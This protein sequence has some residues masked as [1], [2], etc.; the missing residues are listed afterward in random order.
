MAAPPPAAARYRCQAGAG[1]AVGAGGFTLIEI[2]V[3]LA[4]MA[5]VVALVIP[6]LGGKPRSAQLSAAANEISAS[7]R[8]ARSEAILQDRTT[9]FIADPVAGTYTIDAGRHVHHVPPGIALTL[10]ISAREEISPRIGA[11]RFY[12][13]GSSSGGGLAL[14]TAGLRYAVLIDWFDGNVSI[15]A[16]KPAPAR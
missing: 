1:S 13:D 5:L 4:V 16:P 9:R 8:L 15:E 3:V 10:L 14:A 11:V 2:I 7:L 12:P 6:V